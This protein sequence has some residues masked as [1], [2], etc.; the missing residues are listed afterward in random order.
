M[1]LVG[2]AFEFETDAVIALTG[3]DFGA[4]LPLWT[5]VEIR[6]GETVRCGATRSGARCYLAVRGG[7]GVPG[8]WAARRSTS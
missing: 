3:S 2:G 6:A 5:A 4:G 7:I 1:T 8:P